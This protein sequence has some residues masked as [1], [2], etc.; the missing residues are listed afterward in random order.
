MTLLT[1]TEF[2]SFVEAKPAAAVHFDAVWDVGYR[3][4]TRQLML[5]AEAILAD[6]ANF[7]E[8]DCDSDSELAKSI[9]VL[10][11]PMVAYYRDGRLVAALLGSQQNIRA[12][13]EGVLRGE[14]IGY[15]DGFDKPSHLRSSTPQPTPK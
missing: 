12:R 10:G 7:G 6:N 9:P 3:P 11:V 5:D 14:P 1:S 13:L 15:K 4:M 8:V 2:Q